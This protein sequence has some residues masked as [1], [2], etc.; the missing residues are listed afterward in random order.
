MRIGEIATSAEYQMDEQ[1]RSRQFLGANF[2]FPNW[3]NSR[4]LLIFQFR[5]FQTFPIRKTQKISNLKKSKNLE[6]W[7]FQKLPIWKV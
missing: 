2:G 6:F 5:Q 4:N 3:K 1:F 7:K